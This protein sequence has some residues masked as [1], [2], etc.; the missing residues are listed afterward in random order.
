[1]KRIAGNC[2]YS[3]TTHCAV[4]TIVFSET[5]GQGGGDVGDW[6][7]AVGGGGVKVEM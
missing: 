3:L 6:N 4:R 7:F 5:Q 2:V 1:M